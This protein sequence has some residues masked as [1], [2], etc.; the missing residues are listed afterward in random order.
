MGNPFETDKMAAGYATARP[1][2]HAKVIE[3]A[4]QALGR[5]APF[6]RALDVGCGA[7][8]STRALDGFAEHSIGVEPAEPML[9]WHST[10]APASDFVV[11]RAEALPVQDG[12]VDL[13]TAAGALNYANLDQFFPEALRTLTPGGTLLVYDFS[14]GRSFRHNDR[15]DEWFTAFSTRYPW[16]RAEARELNP[17]ILAALDSGCGLRQNE[18]FEIGLTLSPGF[19]LEYM[20]TETNVASAMRS[21]VPYDE[22]R[23][24]CGATLAPVWDGRDHE[25]LFRGYFACLSRQ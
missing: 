1:P 23:Q 25:V 15:L 13:I 22:I 4:H 7:G 10:L 20:L 12:C 16:P 3:R 21:G 8:L 5:P 24:W 14:P 18:Y 9:R 17:E 19:Y 6:R 11:G 2:V